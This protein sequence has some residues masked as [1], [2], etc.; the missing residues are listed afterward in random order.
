MS[1]REPK[2]QTVPTKVLHKMGTK[3]ALIYEYQL[4][5]TQL[6]SILSIYTWLGSTLKY[7]VRAHH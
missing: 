1:L 4:G 2:F 3:Y 5:L 6:D 7:V